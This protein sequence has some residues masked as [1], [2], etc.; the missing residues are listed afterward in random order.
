M[1]QHTL[2]WYRGEL[3]EGVAIAVTAL[4][5]A[6]SVTIA[7]FVSYAPAVK[8]L[9]IPFWLVALIFVG[10]GVAMAWSNYQAMPK[11]EEA[12]QLTAGVNFAQQE[13]ERV[14]SF[15]Y[16]YTATAAVSAVFFLGGVATLLYSHNVI[17]KGVAFTFV[18]TA[19]MLMA[20]DYFS[21]I[22]ADRYKQQVEVYLTQ[23][24]VN[25]ESY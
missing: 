21:K 8:Y 12:Y 20:I 15:Q 25:Q 6:M 22:R 17:I 10:I 9:V 2:A 19:C 13:L 3:L 1:L 4:V 11:V 7:Y 16:L 14:A 23:D 5:L 18:T 24:R